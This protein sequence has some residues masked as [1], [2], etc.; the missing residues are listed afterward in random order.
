M[1]HAWLTTGAQIRAGRALLGCRRKDLAT[2]AGVH[3]NA[4]AYWERRK[5]IPSPPD[6]DMPFACRQIT[7]ALRVNGVVMVKNPGPGVALKAE[8]FQR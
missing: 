2:A 7:E 5:I 1:A 8:T 4:V 3:P 6:G